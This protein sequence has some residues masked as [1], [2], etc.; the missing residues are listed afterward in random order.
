[1]T[2]HQLLEGALQGFDVQRPGQLHRHGDVVGAAPG[3]ELIQEPQPLLCERQ[4][5]GAGA[6]NA[7]QWRRLEA[8]SAGQSGAQTR[9]QLLHRGGFEDVAQ[10]QLDLEGHADPGDELRGE[11]RVAS[12][13]EEVA[14]Q[15]DQIEVEHL[16]EDGRQ[17]L[18]GLRARSFEHFLLR[19]VW[20]RQ[21]P[22][23]H[24]SV[25]RQRQCIQHHVGGR[26]HVLR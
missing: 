25:G 15:A 19:C 13:L 17:L 22:A 24:L 7:L 26:H 5:Q 20:R 3:F 23:V 11:Q 9:G 10:G 6:R 21:G 2:A 4:R 18:L 8:R 1:M 16:R 12:Q 14:V